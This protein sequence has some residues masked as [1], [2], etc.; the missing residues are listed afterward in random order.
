VPVARPQATV[1]RVDGSEGSSGFKLDGGPALFLVEL[2]SAASGA[3]DLQ[4]MQRA[5]RHAVSRQAASGAAI[6]WAAGVLVPA[7]G[8]CLC[9]VEA[10][11]ESDVLDARNIAGLHTAPVRPA[12]VVSDAPATHAAGPT[13]SPDQTRRKESS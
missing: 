7:D 5:L 10:S 2:R 13:T 11:E 3:D 9:L 1:G 8:R 6:R 12:H 4:R